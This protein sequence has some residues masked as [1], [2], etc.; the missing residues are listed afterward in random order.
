M[1]L[2]FFLLLL[3]VTGYL[4]LSI[5]QKRQPRLFHL[6]INEYLASISD[7]TLRV[8]AKLSR[9]GNF[10]SPDQQLGWIRRENSELSFPNGTTI[11]T[12]SLGSRRIPGVSGPATISSFGNSFTEGLEVD[13]GET[14]QAYIAKSTGRA[15]LNFGVSGYGPDQALLALETRLSA[16]I[17]TPIV[18]LAMVNENMNRI[19]N[20][21]RLFYTYPVVDMFLAFK[22]MF[23]EGNDNHELMNFRPSDLTD[24]DQLRAA[25]TEASRYDAFYAARTERLSFP[26]TVNGLRFL[27]RHGMSPSVPWPGNSEAARRRM[28]YI[29]SRFLQNARRYDFKPVFL[30]LPEN[31]RELRQR[32]GS[33]HPFLKSIL[34]KAELDGLMYIDAVQALSGDNRNT[35]VPDFDF[36]KYNRETHPSPYGNQAIATVLVHA[37]ELVSS[38]QYQKQPSQQCRER[39]D[40]QYHEAKSGRAANDLTCLQ[41]EPKFR[42]ESR[43]TARSLLT[44]NRASSRLIQLARHFLKKT[45]ASLRAI[46]PQSAPLRKPVE[47]SES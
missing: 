23:V 27:L 29:L 41:Y 24:R 37:L 36:N 31:T 7:E 3:E 13:D 9:K 25:M 16:G 26:Y 6:D 19:M 28:S 33:D 21:F 46:R 40:W 38:E 4:F 34:E 47:Y 20:D 18:I 39:M 11:S 45:R 1:A 14:W 44:P 2:M 15:V 42:G 10:Y 8:S 12:D 22:P 30:L 35:Y 43:T 17:W 32:R 5:Q